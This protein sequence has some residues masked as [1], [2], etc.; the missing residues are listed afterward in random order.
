MT[1]FWPDPF[2]L[3]RLVLGSRKIRVT[4]RMVSKEGDRGIAMKEYPRYAIDIERLI[5]MIQPSKATERY[6][7]FRWQG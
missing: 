3:T 6:S 7:E 5:S 4:V 1:T 2:S